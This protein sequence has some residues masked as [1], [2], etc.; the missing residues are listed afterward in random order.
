MGAVALNPKPLLRNPMKANLL[1]MKARVGGVQGVQA[2]LQVL[3]DS[4]S[5]D[6]GCRAGFRVEGFRG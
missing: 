1:W 3:R 2:G 4:G 5:G 6:W